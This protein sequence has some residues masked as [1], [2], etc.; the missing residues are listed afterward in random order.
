[1]SSCLAIETQRLTKRFGKLIAVN[2][3]NLQVPLGSIYGFLGP[4]GAG[5]TTTFRM[6]VGLAKRDQGSITICDVEAGFGKTN[7]QQLIGFL[8]D[9]PVF[10]GWMT[11]AEV[12]RFFGRLYNIPVSQLSARV[13]RL[14]AQVGLSQTTKKI[15][16]FSRGMKKRLGIAQALL[17]EPKVILLDE[18]T[19]ALDPIGRDEVFEIIANLNHQNI[20][21]IL[22]THILD[23][24][25]KLCNYVG[26]INNGALIA[27]DSIANLAD[28]FN[29]RLIKIQ[30]QGDTAAFL[31]ELRQ[32]QWITNMQTSDEPGAITL[33][34]KDLE[35]AQRSL[36]AL[37]AHHTLKL[38]YFR[39]DRPDVESIFRLLIGRDDHAKGSGT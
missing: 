35:A 19:A 36:P 15:R 26:I 27:Q 4:N 8:P 31:T 18:P 12:L 33:E 24:V 13:D 14:L 34:V 16:S 38:E 22:S 10:Y 6:L 2:N 32:Q 3:L 39:I 30:V 29:A 1:M 37:V 23:D 20:T 9:D 21:V 28:Q 5:K 25:Q 17:S 7:F 11:A